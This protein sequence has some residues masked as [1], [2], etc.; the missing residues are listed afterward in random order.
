MIQCLANNFGH[1]QML[2]TSKQT[3]KHSEDMLLAIYKILN[4]SGGV[5]DVS[6]KK[7]PPFGHLQVL[8]F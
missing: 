6:A 2:V 5:I 8:D 3:L 1:W 4:G 7:A